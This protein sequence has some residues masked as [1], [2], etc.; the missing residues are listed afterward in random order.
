MHR[1]T[2]KKGRNAWAP[3]RQRGKTLSQ[4]FG[5]AFDHPG[6][7]RSLARKSRA[8][9]WQAG[10]ANL[11]ATIQTTPKTQGRANILVGLVLA[12]I[13]MHPRVPAIPIGESGRRLLHAAQPWP[14]L[15]QVQ[16]TVFSLISLVFQFGFIFQFS[17]FRVSGRFSLFG[18]FS[19]FKK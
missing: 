19:R 13:Q 16:L 6:I 14:G 18:R 11:L 8:R 7:A 1:I 5:E 3:P 9:R 12:V 17:F 15:G 4:N 10:R 2:F